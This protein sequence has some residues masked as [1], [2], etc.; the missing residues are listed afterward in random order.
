[1]PTN[2]STTNQS[3]NHLSEA[4]RGE[5]EAYISVGLK[6]AEIARRLGRNRSTIIRGFITQV[7]KGKWAESLLPTLLCRCCS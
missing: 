6:P 1:M 3:Y 2:Y 4:E 5:I 7:K